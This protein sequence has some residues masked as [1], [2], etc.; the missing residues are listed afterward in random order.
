[1]I[2]VNFPI[3]DRLA[4]VAAAR[5]WL[6]TP[7]HHAADVPGVG[8]DCAMILVRIFCDLRLVERFDPRPYT[9]DWM[10]HRDEEKYLGFLLASARPVEAPQLGDIVLFRVGRCFSHGGVV[11]KV[12]ALTIVHAYAPAACVVEE[13]VARSPDLARREARYFSHWG[14]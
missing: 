3:A 14:S 4:V 11:T 13:E 5:R 8:A 6:G 10:L 9:R 12:D 2:D 7:Y 1:M